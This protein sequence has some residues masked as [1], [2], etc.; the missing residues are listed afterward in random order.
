MIQIGDLTKEYEKK[1]TFLK[2]HNNEP[3]LNSSVSAT[4]KKMGEKS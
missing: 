3:T 1:D 2:A 4:V